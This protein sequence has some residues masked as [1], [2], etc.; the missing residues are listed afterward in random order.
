MKQKRRLEYKWII[1][2]VCFLMVFVTLGFCSSNKGLYLS[3]VTKALGFKR[4]LF[5]IS[6][7]C[8]FISSA[9]INLFFG[10]LIQRFGVRKMAIFGF[11][12]VISSVLLYA[13]AEHILLFYLGGA[14]L[15]VGLTFTTN[16]M[17]S[18]VIRRW[19]HKDIGRYTGIVMAANG[20]GGAVAAKLVTPLINQES[21]LF[22]YR[23][24]YFLVIAIVAVTG[25]LVALL[26]RQPPENPLPAPVK[27]T[28]R[29][30][31]WV[32][33][34][35][36]TVKKKPYFYLIGLV[37]FLTGFMLQGVGGINTAHMQDV[38]FDPTAVAN[39]AAI[40]SLMLTVSKILVGFAY[41]K[42]GLR[43]ILIVCQLAAA[44]AC[45]VL[46]LLSASGVALGYI[47][48]VLYAL[49]LPLETL[50]I[51][52]IVSDLFGSAAY[53]KILGI[54]IAMN[55]TGYALGGP[56]LNLCYD[57]LGTYK[58]ML[59]I[60]TGVVL[61]A[62]VALQPILTIANKEKENVL[63]SADPSK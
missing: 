9:I 14:L 48:A 54:Y 61:M 43:F 8:R 32:G 35:F 22:G 20:V 21:T 37:V 59:L 27:K 42:F 46:G 16:T 36:D 4:S 49:A 50:V 56:M 7:S 13:L 2:S 5:S 60:Y 52:L 45:G 11:L 24:A 62:C 6:D 41:D 33:I 31:V 51:P 17:A 26:L 55:Y 47:F 38:G 25:I 53:D 10:A 63:V 15:G 23:D 3:A 57:L 30:A 58:P 34:E 19:F 44:V 28:S 18:S 39:I 12:S 40:S 29:S 1:L